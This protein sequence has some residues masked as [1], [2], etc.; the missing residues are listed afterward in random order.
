MTL[1][2]TYL[3]SSDMSAAIAAL[4]GAEDKRTVKQAAW[5]ALANAAGQTL[6]AAQLLAGYLD[7][8][9]A[10]GVSDATPTAA[11]LVA[12]FAGCAVGDVVTLRIRNRNT[13]TLTLTAG[14]GVTLEGTTTIPT[15]NTREYAIRFTNVTVGAEAVTISGVFVAAN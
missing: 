10:A 15:V 5:N 13:G 7:R 2:K 1:K 11:A 8:S 3:D 6:T 12:L 9:G 4:A 14:V